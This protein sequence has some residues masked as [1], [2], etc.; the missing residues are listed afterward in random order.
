[1]NNVFS[2]EIAWGWHIHIIFGG[3]LLVGAILLIIWAAKFMS[4]KA[5]QNWTIWLIV[6]GVIGVLLTAGLG[7]NGW[8]EMMRLNNGLDLDTLEEP[9]DY[10]LEK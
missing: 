9:S 4:K 2:N 1:M 8:K 7:F 3:T 5:L 6:I 10:P